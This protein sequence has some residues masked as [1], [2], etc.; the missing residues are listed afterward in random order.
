MSQTRTPGT[1][2]KS[3][4]VLREHA[5]TSLGAAAVL[6]VPLAF[7]ATYA[8]LEP[9][10]RS[11]LVGLMVSIAIGVAVAYS[12]TVAVGMY[13][14]NADPG[15]GALLKKTFGRGLVGF[16]ATRVLAGLVLAVAV[17]V[18]MLPFLYALV[19]AGPAVFDIDDPPRAE[20]LLLTST[21]VLSAPVGLFLLLYAYLQVGL[22]GPARVLENLSP[23][24]SLTRSGSV[25]KGKRM[26]FF[27]VLVK[28]TAVRIILSMVLA[29]PASIVGAGPDPFEQPPANPFSREFLLE[30]FSQSR[31]L[32]V[33]AALVVGI[34]TYLGAVAVTAVSATVLAEFFIEIRDRR[35]RKSL[36]GG[37]S[38]A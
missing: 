27:V 30:I 9:G 35:E 12:N 3:F 36:Q 6:C 15:P 8:A 18:G 16:A 20:M 34:S 11:L 21:L 5:S 26:E 1:I 19:T 7:T 14:E 32:G 4:R 25:T 13:A 10:P 23:I 33:A 31:P 38:V 37:E 17:A 29:G 22:A 28:L 2:V 24:Q